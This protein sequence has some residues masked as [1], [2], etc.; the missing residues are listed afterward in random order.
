M[1]V[2]GPVSWRELLSLAFWF[3]ACLALLGYVAGAFE[4]WRDR[5][6]S[7]PPVNR[8]KVVNRDDQDQSR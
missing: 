4:R 1:D 6:A 8:R 5:P 3:A 2:T 7:P